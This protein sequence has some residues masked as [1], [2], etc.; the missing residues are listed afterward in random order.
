[1]QNVTKKTTCLSDLIKVKSFTKEPNQINGEYQLGIDV[2]MSGY[3]PMGV[4]GFDVNNR[5]NTSITSVLLVGNTVIFKG[6]TSDLT[7]LTPKATVLFFK[8]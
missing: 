3:V 7:T 4:V 8:A 2:S 6:F 5:F 1:M